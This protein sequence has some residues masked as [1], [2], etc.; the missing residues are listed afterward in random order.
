MS[1][2]KRTH[3]LTGIDLQ[4]EQFESFSNFI[5][6]EKDAFCEYAFNIIQ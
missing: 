1:D 5:Q 4:V 6:Y 2:V 3:A